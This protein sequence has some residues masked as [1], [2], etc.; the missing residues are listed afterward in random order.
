MGKTVFQPKFVYKAGSKLNSVSP[1]QF[2]NPCSRQWD[3]KKTSATH[4]RRLFLPSSPK[5]GQGKEKVNVS[6]E[7]R[8]KYPIEDI[9]RRHPAILKVITEHI[10]TGLVPGK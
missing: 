6:C 10:E 7:Y 2:A 9:R 5:S 8:S 1:P 3:K 4:L